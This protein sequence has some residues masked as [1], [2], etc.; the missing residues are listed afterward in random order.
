VRLLYISTGAVPSRWAHSFQSMKM[1]EALSRQVSDLE[2]LTTGSLLHSPI[3]DVPLR[4]WYGLRDSFRV[5]RLPVHWRL[6]DPFI[7]RVSNPRF[8][9]AAVAYARWHRPDLVVA[10][11]PEAGIGCARAGIP[12]ILE[13]HSVHKVGVHQ[14]AFD[15]IAAIAQRNSLLGL[16]T[17]TEYLREQYAGLGVP[18]DKLMV[19]PDAVDPAVFDQAPSRVEA[20]RSFGL[21]ED[22]PVAVYCGHFYPEKGVDH[23]IDAAAK[24]PEVTFCLVGGTPKDTARLR[25]LAAAA[26]NVRFEGFVPNRLVP[27]YLSA[28][29]LVVIPSSGRFEHAR[30][31]S[32]LKLFESMAAG[33]PI[34]ATRVP[35]LET[36]LQ[37]RENAWLVDPDSGGA[38]A[39]GVLALTRDEELSRRLADQA[40]L[41]V[42]PY[43]WERRAREILAR[44]A[45]GKSMHGAG[46]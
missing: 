15:P 6:R 27:S 13:Y 33:R 43:T 26:R 7:T 25:G 38:L 28:A 11:S 31:A 14:P 34:V 46:A 9:R 24:A 35:A 22:A 8:D 18:E 37:H 17:V 23:L 2:L 42:A 45:G 5:V 41:D 21:P 4:T 10:R 12:T 32:P 39:E 40:R 16:V 29:N 36:W 30:A 19:W 3:H 1:A 20:R 44:F